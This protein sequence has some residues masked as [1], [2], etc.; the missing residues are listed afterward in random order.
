[1]NRQTL[2]GLLMMTLILPGCTSTTV[3][4]LKNPNGQTGEV[5][6]KTSTGTQTLSHPGASTK[7]GQSNTRSKIPTILKELQINQM[8]AKTLTNEPPAPRRFPIHFRSNSS[9]IEEDA[10]NQLR[11]AYSAIRNRKSCDIR[12]IG[13]TSGGS[14]DG[15]KN[16]ALSLKQAEQVKMALL[17]RSIDDNCLALD[18]YGESDPLI[19]TAAGKIN[20]NNQRVEIEIR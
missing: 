20:P 4:L 11:L 9:E 10:V 2:I 17:E 5:T 15:K 3:V 14:V 18:Y 6:V 16:Q 8:F 1:M 19:Q 12:I 13:H 7:T